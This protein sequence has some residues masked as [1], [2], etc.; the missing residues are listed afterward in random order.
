[1]RLALL[2]LLPWLV[3]TQHPVGRADGVS[4][5][6]QRLQ[7]IL[8]GRHYWEHQLTV[9]QRREARM[10]HRLAH[11]KWRLLRKQARLAREQARFAAQQAQLLSAI[12]ADQQRVDQVRSQLASTRDEYATVHRQAAGLLA[13]LR[14][15]RAEI[16]RQLGNVSEALVQMYDLSQVSPL[17]SVLEAHNLTDLLNQQN[18]VAEIGARD[19]AILHRA[20]V[21]HAAVYRVA[22]VYIDKMTELKA[23]QAQETAELNTVV[24]QT[25]HEDLLLI[26]ARQLSARRQ[27]HMRRQEAAVTALA[28]E[29]KQQLA[30]ISSSAESASQQIQQDQNAAEKAAIIIGE[31]T[32]NY[33]YVGGP[34]TLQWP[35][36]GIITQSFG[37]S[38]YAFEPPLE[39]HGTYY[40]HFHTGLDIAAPFDTPIRA[41]A[42]GRVI[43][44][45]LFVPGQPHVAYGL[46][47]II[48]HT[49]HLST[50]YAHMDLALGLRV[51]VGQLVDAGQ[52]I[53]YE[54]LTGNTTGPHL[55]FEVRVDGQY[56]NPL[57]YLPRNQN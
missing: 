54:G 27:G 1:M 43:F 30:D 41:A 9:Q 7:Q 11:T 53:G 18:F 36:T 16:H 52:V 57:D 34:T 42:P 6:T 39:Y 12:T 2:V 14:R 47:V 10:Q 51:H 22:K 17:E 32:G 19:N 20:R 49:E 28:R 13:R 55:H 26:E 45:S 25:Q 8:A 5:E 21:E 29:E 50:L 4:T 15:L 40:A 37:P 46:C 48:Q 38:P 24:V 23:L 31:A 44:A 35:L 56:M 3:L 33:P